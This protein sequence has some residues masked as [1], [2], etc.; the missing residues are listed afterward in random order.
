MKMYSLIWVG[1]VLVDLFIKTH[2]MLRF[3]GQDWSFF[4]FANEQESS[5]QK[6]IRG[7]SHGLYH[8]WITY[9][10]SQ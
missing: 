7:S 2:Q 4:Q 6:L 5:D 8:E 1:W 3:Y 9:V 10:Q